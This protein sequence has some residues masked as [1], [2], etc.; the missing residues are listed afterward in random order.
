MTT[1]A[2]KLSSECG[3]FEC[4]ASVELPQMK[5]ARD[6]VLAGADK[7]LLCTSNPRIS[8]VFEKWLGASAYGLGE[9]MAA[10]LNPELFSCGEGYDPDVIFNIDNEREMLDAIGGC[11]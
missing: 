6:A 2:L 9:G 5:A 7:V 1:F 11:Q 8:V 3:E 4:E 10:E